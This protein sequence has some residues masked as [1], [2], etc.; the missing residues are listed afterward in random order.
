MV[1]KLIPASIVGWVR[2]VILLL[3]GLMLIFAAPF[4]LSVLVLSKTYEVRFIW[5]L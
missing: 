2:T 5:R 3:I 4:I 1:T